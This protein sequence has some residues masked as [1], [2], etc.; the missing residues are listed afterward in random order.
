MPVSLP[1]LTFLLMEAHALSLGNPLWEAE[2]CGRVT[3]QVLSAL[4]NSS[5]LRA[6]PCPGHPKG[7][8]RRW[9]GGGRAPKHHHP[10]SR[11]PAD[12]GPESPLWHRTQDLLC[13][14]AFCWPWGST[15]LIQEAENQSC[16][17]TDSNKQSGNSSISLMEAVGQGWHR[18]VSQ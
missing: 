17:H 1:A 3:P 11:A 14:N 18:E 4:I 13:M 7:E 12:I 10:L 6:W 9:V 15:R 16:V 2:A 5:D 8:T